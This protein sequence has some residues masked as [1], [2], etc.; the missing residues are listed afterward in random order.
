MFSIE[1]GY[2]NLADIDE[3]NVNYDVNGDGYENKLGLKDIKAS[4]IA[5]TGLASYPIADNLEVFGKAGI[6][7]WEAES[8]IDEIDDYDAEDYV[9]DKSDLTQEV[10]GTDILLGVGASY[11]F[12]ENLGIRGEYE[13]VGGDLEA[14]IYSIGATFSSL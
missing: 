7:K 9:S 13:Y 10:D 6:M 8:T 1:G 3:E 2:Y 14:N 4:G 11:Q 5:L 12:T